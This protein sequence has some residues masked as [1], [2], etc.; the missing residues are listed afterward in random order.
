MKKFKIGYVFSDDKSVVHYVGGYGVDHEDAMRN[1]AQN[2]KGLSF[3]VGAV[4]CEEVK[5]EE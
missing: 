3:G 1:F 5:E 4:S 2:I